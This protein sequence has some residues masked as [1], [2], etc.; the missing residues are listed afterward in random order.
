MPFLILLLFI[1]VPIAEIALFIEI[2]GAIG[3]VWTVITIFATAIIGTWLV[4]QQGLQT[5]ERARAAMNRN[6]MPVDEVIAGL[7]ILVAGALLL[8]PGF[9]TDAL[10][11]VLLIPPMRAALAKT[12]IGSMRASGRF[13]VHA[14]GLGGASN[15]PGGGPGRGGRGPVI[16]GEF[17]EVSDPDPSSPWNRDGNRGGNESLPPSDDTP[18]RKP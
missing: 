13:H 7:C 16:D 6:Q 14:G 9:L 17:E 11:F 10:G 8:T 2:G 3:T 4:R 18:E 15:P 1:A 12:V 5:M